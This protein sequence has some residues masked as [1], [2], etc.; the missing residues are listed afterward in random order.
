MSSNLP[1]SKNIL[2]IRSALGKQIRTT[3]AYFERILTVKHPELNEPLKE[4]L[5]TFATPD[6][7]RHG[8]QDIYLYYRRSGQ[9]W[10]V[11]VARH[12]NGDGFLITAYKT[13]KKKRK[14]IIVWQKRK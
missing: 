10:L 4:V 1:D 12:L 13:S 11:A 5:N 3:S 6:E 2:E 14:G 9:R 7:V 8:G